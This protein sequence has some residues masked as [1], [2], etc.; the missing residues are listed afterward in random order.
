MAVTC[1]HLGA[2]GIMR[3]VSGKTRRE[4]GTGPDNRPTAS[5]R[6]P[7]VLLLQLLGALVLCWLVLVGIA[8]AAPF[9]AML[10]WRDRR[11]GVDFMPDP[12]R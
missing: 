1:Y 3:K 9:L 2:D 5:R 12:M 6:N 4:S 8:C 11:R 10:E 7:L